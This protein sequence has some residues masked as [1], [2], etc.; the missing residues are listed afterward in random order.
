MKVKYVKMSASAR[1]IG[2]SN[3][4][5]FTFLLLSNHFYMNS[6]RT[7]ERKLIMYGGECWKPYSVSLMLSEVNSV[8]Q[9]MLR[10]WKECKIK[11]LGILFHKGFMWFTSF[12]SSPE[13]N[14]LRIE[15][16]LWC[17]ILF[18]FLLPRMLSNMLLSLCVISRANILP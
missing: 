15:L 7:V 16:F 1:W 6:Q 12:T 18:L 17:E 11:D 13:T 5:L 2:W 4:V 9:S 3:A 8:L 10:L 14:S